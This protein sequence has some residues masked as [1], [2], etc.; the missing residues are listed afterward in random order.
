MRPV[1]SAALRYGGKQTPAFL[2]IVDTGSDLCM[3]DDQLLL[4]LGLNAYQIG[5]QSTAIGIGG[6]EQVAVFPIE[7]VFPALN[8]A[9]WEIH[10]RFKRMPESV[11]GVLGHAGFLGRMRASFAHAKTFELSEVKL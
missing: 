4:L 10:A 9:A 3:F 6:A 7:V 2:S 11:P 1:L 8:N 5:A